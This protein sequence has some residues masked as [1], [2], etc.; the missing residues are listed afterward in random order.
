MR[1]LDLEGLPDEVVD[2]VDGGTLEEGQRHLVDEHGGPVPL[3]DDV[4][5]L[6]RPLDVE[7]VL[8]AGAAAAVDADA[9]HR[10]G[11][12]GAHDLVD[13]PRGPFRE[14]DLAHRAVQLAIISEAKVMAAALG[15]N[16]EAPMRPFG[17]RWT[18]PYACDPAASRGR[19][20]PEAASPT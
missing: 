19:L 5:R 2:E 17:E 4:V 1:V 15:F 6:R 20:H 16:L 10:P 9:Q 3:D 18:A 12:L 7:G 13:A 11:G 8:E 14:A